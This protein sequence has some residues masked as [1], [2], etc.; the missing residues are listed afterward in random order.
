L[1]LD[2]LPDLPNLNSSWN[3]RVDAVASRL[4]ASAV[5]ENEI[6][7][8]VEMAREIRRSE[9]RFLIQRDFPKAY[10]G[11][12]DKL[13]QQ[14]KDQLDIDIEDDYRSEA[15]RLSS[16][17]ASLHKLAEFLGDDATRA[18][19][20]AD[21]LASRASRLED[22]ARDEDEEPEDDADFSSWQREN[23]DVRNIFID[24]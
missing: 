15:S 10:E 4:S 7:R 9:P 16:L 3:A 17:S 21:R 23:I 8:W 19:D 18:K 13:L 6:E 1:L 12:I 20:V 22:K 24:L 5:D 14:A 2:P 11:E